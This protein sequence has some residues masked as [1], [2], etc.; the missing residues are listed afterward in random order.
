MYAGPA[1]TRLN[2]DEEEEEH[3]E[4]PAGVTYLEGA[5]KHMQMTCACMLALHVHS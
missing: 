1:C 4:E 5:Q 2:A 3:L